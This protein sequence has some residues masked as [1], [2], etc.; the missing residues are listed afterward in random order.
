MPAA[1]NF[2]AFSQLLA[3]YST[4]DFTMSPL[5]DKGTWCLLPTTPFMP[6]TATKLFVRAAGGGGCW[7]NTKGLKKHE[8]K[9]K[10][11]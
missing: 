7:T 8:N 9:G 6:P 3:A 11:K 2:A 5:A 4:L 1:G 10:K